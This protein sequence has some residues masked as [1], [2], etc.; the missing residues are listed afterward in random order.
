MVK[1]RSSNIVNALRETPIVDADHLPMVHLAIPSSVKSTANQRFLLLSKHQ[2]LAADPEQY[3]NNKLAV[4]KGVLRV[5][6]HPQSVL[7]FANIA[8]S[9]INNSK[10]L[11]LTPLNVNK[12]LTSSKQSVVSLRIDFP[13][14]IRK[15]CYIFNFQV[16]Q[17]DQKSTIVI[18]LI[19]ENGILVTL[20]FN[21]DSDFNLASSKSKN[22]AFS[23]VERWC[24]VSIP[25]DFDVREPHYLHSITAN[26]FLVFF[27][28]G[29][30][31]KCARSSFKDD[32]QVG[33]F[34]DTS[35]VSSTLGRFGKFLPLSKRADYDEDESNYNI[36]RGFTLKTNLDAIVINNEWLV[37]VSFNRKL[38]I[39]SLNTGTL[40]SEQKL[41]LHDH[42]ANELLDHKLIGDGSPSNLL[43][44]LNADDCK[45]VND[46]QTQQ[47]YFINYLPIGDGQFKLWSL[48]ISNVDNEN[49]QIELVDVGAKFQYRP[50]IPDNNSIWL[51]KDFKLVDKSFLDVDKKFYNN[52]DTNKKPWLNLV[53]LLKSNTSSMYQLLTIFE[54]GDHNW[55]KSKLSLQIFPDTH[56]N[57]FP[58]SNSQAVS[59]FFVK[60][61]L[62]SNAYSN[63]VIETALAFFEQKYV[64]KQIRSSIPVDLPIKEK[65]SVIVG[66]S[67]NSS[68]SSDYVNDIL[69]QWQSFESLCQELLK[70]S[71]ESL[72][73]SIIQSSGTNTS[74]FF[75]SKCLDY[76]A[77]RTSDDIE[78][79]FLSR[80]K[81]LSDLPLLSTPGTIESDYKNSCGIENDANILKFLS[82]ISNFKYTLSSDIL[83]NVKSLLLEQNF[84][85]TIIEQSEYIFSKCLAGRISEDSL[86]KLMN[87]LNSIPD[88]FK[89]IG[90]L[91]E[92]PQ[93]VSLKK[94]LTLND[95]Y[96]QDIKQQS[97][98]ADSL[99][100]VYLIQSFKQYLTIFEDIYYNL[101]LVTL[102]LN[103]DETIASV[104]LSKA[105]A[106][107]KKIHLAYET[108]QIKFTYPA[109]EE[110]ETALQGV[111]I[112]ADEGQLED[113]SSLNIET[114][115]T[116]I[117]S[118]FYRIAQKH[119]NL[120][121]A[122]DGTSNNKILFH[123][124]TD[125]RFYYAVLNEL[126]TTNNSEVIRNSILGYESTVASTS[127]AASSLPVLHLFKGLTY[128]NSNNSTKALNILTK[129][130]AQIVSCKPSRDELIF[131]DSLVQFL[132]VESLSEFYHTLAIVFK[133]LFYYSN[134]LSL[135]KLAIK[136]FDTHDSQQIKDNHEKR[137]IMKNYHLTYFNIALELQNFDAAFAAL[138]DL[139][140]DPKLD[141]PETSK[142]IRHEALKGFIFT[143]SRSNDLKNF[144]TYAFPPS[145]VVQ[146][147][148]ILF[149]NANSIN[150]N[151]KLSA[152]LHAINKSLTHGLKYFK[153]LYAWRL[154]HG[155]VRGATEALYQYI[156]KFRYLCSHPKRGRAV[157]DITKD[158][159]FS[160]VLS[161]QRNI[162]G[163]LYLIIINLM[164]T[165]REP[166]GAD[167]SDEQWLLKQNLKYV[168][169]NSSSSGSGKSRKS[170][171]GERSGS[172]G[173]DN[174]YEIL[175]YDELK[176]EYER[177]L[178]GHL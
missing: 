154:N 138:L 72:S 172:G 12:N 113:S 59:E 111:K 149:Q 50:I 68:I 85:G 48:K 104:I 54:D 133:D 129:H 166:S 136:Q 99:L 101:V 105:L 69:K 24:F 70:I 112:I 139:T 97:T 51:V 134:A 29:G 150:F 19:T 95:K 61:I 42:Q 174:E 130:A 13:E 120:N 159:K 73:L 164:D 91:L 132:D 169:A 66:K 151:M 63:V 67:V 86:Q 22:D 45:N 163:E 20:S 156:N 175:K 94:Y 32:V 153:I 116:L 102:I 142:S 168:Y 37:T 121:V 7:P 17:Q 141:D 25:Y 122:T 53:V 1:V 8:W 152:S 119:L 44:A 47:F 108:L 28:D 162:I 148:E 176:L 157:I 76:S 77:V 52:K 14:N 126:S 146:V 34:S 96:L 75:V 33:L 40:L 110:P 161:K 31:I 131:L 165:L 82:V 26:E 118:L 155:N 11:V 10:S 2:Q 62:N 87:D 124:I 144:I 145:D 35:Y 5:P 137:I 106:T 158:A 140:I 80:N 56:P 93:K 128:L 41:L 88:A 125:E 15:N 71:N 27:K 89:I 16:G 23:A 117:N 9:V 74:S 38:K 103:F 100:S 36:P 160:G 4:D 177:F 127:S 171:R 57:N 78:I 79:L 39:W 173:D 115:G 170:I 3:F 21:L 109:T 178:D 49:N 123:F 143:I 135:V 114:I 58:A 6:D 64:S 92:Y 18:D 81:L 30:I 107:Y 65:V 55:V 98:T 46:S 83:I 43:A 60:R 90:Y 167:G 84:Q 147:D